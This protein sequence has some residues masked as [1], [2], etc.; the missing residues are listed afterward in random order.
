MRGWWV[1]RLSAPCSTRHHLMSRFPHWSVNLLSCLRRRRARAIGAALFI[2][3]GCTKDS[4]SPDH[5]VASIDVLPKTARMWIVGDST[6]FTASIVTAAGT[7]GTG[8]PVIWTARDAALLRVVNGVATSLRKGSSTYVVA[9]AGGK[10]D[11]ALVEV[12][13]TPCAA[14]APTSLA[15]GQ[16]V[17]G[18]GANGFC[19]TDTPGAEY[20]V[21]VFNASLVSS[22]SV[23]IEAIGQGLAATPISGSASL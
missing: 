11:S 7:S 10:S 16:V 8:I 6:T 14:V 22:A 15:V 23:T 1:G 19:A 20:T 9:T 18:I 3:T 13:A 21:L 2:A 12:P 4:T 17:T 5:T